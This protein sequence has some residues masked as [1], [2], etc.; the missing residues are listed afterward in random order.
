MRRKSNG[1]NA[2][3][4]MILVGGIFGVDAM[5]VQPLLHICFDQKPLQNQPGVAES[6]QNNAKIYQQKKDLSES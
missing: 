3:P 1:R 2:K 4:W 5:V 6:E